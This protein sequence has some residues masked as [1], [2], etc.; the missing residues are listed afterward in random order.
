[1]S[2]DDHSRLH[3]FL[4]NRENNPYGKL[5]HTNSAPMMIPRR[6]N[7]NNYSLSE[8]DQKQ[9]NTLQSVLMGDIP[10]AYSHL[11]SHRLSPYST[12]PVQRHSPKLKVPSHFNNYSIHPTNPGSPHDQSRGVSPCRSPYSG[13][14]D[15]ENPLYLG[16]SKLDENICGL[17]HGIFG[18]EIE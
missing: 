10:P 13:K 8:C 1:V 9:S 11:T 16:N 18:D 12:S 4:R 3:N 5:N 17:P 6:A 14:G 7:S 2:Y 15:I